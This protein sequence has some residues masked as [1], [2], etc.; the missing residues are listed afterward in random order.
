MK[1][2]AE[3]RAAKE[4]LLNVLK[5]LNVLATSHEKIMTDPNISNEEK[6][7][8][9]VLYKRYSST[10]SVYLSNISQNESPV[11]QQILQENQAIIDKI[12]ASVDKET[13]QQVTQD[14]IE[15]G[16]W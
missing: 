5:N 10:F 2:S 4:T 12:T 7:Q 14:T 1:N 11:I 16:P 9:D 3:E 13:I 6:K 15:L 8:V